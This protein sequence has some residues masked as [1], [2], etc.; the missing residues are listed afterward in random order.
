MLM[1]VSYESCLFS[2]TGIWKLHFY[3]YYFSIYKESLKIYISFLLYLF[4]KLNNIFIKRNFVFAKIFIHIYIS[5]FL[6]KRNFYLYINNNKEARELIIYGLIHIWSFLYILLY[7]FYILH[8]FIYGSIEIYEWKIY[9]LFFHWIIL[10]SWGTTT[11][12]FIDMTAQRENRAKQ[13]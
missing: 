5:Y 6:E 8:F 7:L 1:F 2:K 10:A 12:V 3:Y 11:V 9:L 13:K 4:S